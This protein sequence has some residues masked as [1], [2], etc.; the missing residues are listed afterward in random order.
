MTGIVNNKDY[1][2]GS[3]RKTYGEEQCSDGFKAEPRSEEYTQ[4]TN[5]KDYPNKNHSGMSTHR[6]SANVAGGFKASPASPETPVGPTNSMD[7]DKKSLNYNDFPSES[8]G[9]SIMRMP[10]AL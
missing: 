7:Y 3:S 9:E 1:T 5:S 10:K 8:Q 2:K 4:V 6:A